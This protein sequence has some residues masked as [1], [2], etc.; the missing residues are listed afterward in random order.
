MSRSPA[1]PCTNGAYAFIAGSIYLT[2][3]TIVN[4]LA[5][6]WLNAR[7]GIEHDDAVGDF[8]SRMHI[9]CDYDA[10]HR[11]PLPSADHQFV[12]HVAHDGIQA[13]GRFV[14][15][16]ELWL[17]YQRPGQTNSFA[18]TA[19]ELRGAFGN[20]VVGQATSANRSSTICSVR[21]PPYKP[22]C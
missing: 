21:R 10:G 17:Q 1:S 3:W 14:V 8:A 22:C 18:H 15:Q 11:L 5:L 6:T 2:G 20:H 12:D 7:K 19:R 9:V 16:H 4:Y 13:S